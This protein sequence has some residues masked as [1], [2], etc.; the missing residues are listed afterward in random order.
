MQK[1]RNPLAKA[2]MLTVAFSSLL[3][4]LIASA[5]LVSAS[6]ATLV[7]QNN[8]GVSFHASSFTGTLAFSSSVTSG[9]VV[10]LGLE[11]DSTTSILS[12]TDSLGSSYTQAV[13]VGPSSIS[14][15][16]AAIYYA[17]LGSSG[18]D[19]VMVQVSTSN[20]PGGPSTCHDFFDVYIYEVSGVTTSG[21]TTG[22]GSGTGNSVSTTPTSFATGAFLL[23]MTSFACSGGPGGICSTSAGSG[24]T[25]SPDHSGVDAT[26]AE[27]SLSSVSS[28]T[29]FPATLG[30]IV[31]DWVEA[32]LVV[33]PKNSP[34]IPEYPLGLPLLAIFLI[35]TYGLMRRRAVAQRRSE[36]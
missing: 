35:I 24:F 1:L 6:S 2:L 7:Q 22:S 13:T 16:F 36:T 26:L 18:V 33:N 27:Y 4:A 14:G 11:F 29:T 32:G 5:N 31:V 28:P 19:S 9:D 34:P 17:T 3:L 12:V 23:G 10:A 30:G 25:L 20:C 8:Q 15:L 21:A